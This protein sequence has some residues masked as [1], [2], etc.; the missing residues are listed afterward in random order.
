MA[1]V[2]VPDRVAGDLRLE[3][4]NTRA[5]RGTPA[6]R[7]YLVDDRALVVWAVDAGL[8]VGPAAGPPAG[9]G[10]GSATR[11]AHRLREALYRCALGSGTAADWRLVGRLATRARTRAVFEAGPGGR[12]RWRVT[13][14]GGAC[15][16]VW[17]ALAVDAA[18][19]A[20]EDALRH[21]AGTVAAC[22]GGGCGWIVVDP[23]GRRRW[24]SMAVCGN[25]AKAR[26]YAARARSDRT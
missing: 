5:G 19:L 25:R 15:E 10:R 7:E 11:T 9:A 20:A 13:P 2:A 21:P 14:P 22:P 12:G 23:R 8:L 16:E 3:L 1:G 6:P 17:A 18:A 26:R 24:C 4:C